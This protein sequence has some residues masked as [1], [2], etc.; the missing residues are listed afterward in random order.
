MLFFQNDLKNFKFS[1]R[2]EKIEHAR[3]CAKREEKRIEEMDRNADHSFASMPE[4]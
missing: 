1:Y 2:F 4:F 3:V